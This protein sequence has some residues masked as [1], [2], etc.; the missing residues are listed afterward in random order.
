MSWPNAVERYV[1]QVIHRDFW[2]SMVTNEVYNIYTFSF[3][4]VAIMVT[5]GQQKN[6]KR[7]MVHSHGKVV[8]HWPNIQPK[9]FL[10][11]LV[12]SVQF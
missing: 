1:V 3:F 6:C 11:Q 5:N 2:W 9:L 12:C 4:E 8:N 7:I 10:E